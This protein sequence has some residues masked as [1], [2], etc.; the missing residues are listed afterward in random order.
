MELVLSLG[1]KN[2][3]FI[4]MNVSWD[5]GWDCLSGTLWDTSWDIWHPA[6]EALVALPNPQESSSHPRNES[7]PWFQKHCF[8]KESRI[9][10]GSWVPVSGCLGFAV[11]TQSRKEEHVSS[12][13]PQLE[14]L[15]ASPSRFPPGPTWPHL[16]RR[17]SLEVRGQGLSHCP[18]VNSFPSKFRPRGICWHLYPFAWSSSQFLPFPT[19]DAP[20]FTPL[21]AFQ[22][23]L[24]MFQG[25]RLQVFE[26]NP[27]HS[28]VFCV[29]ESGPSGV[30]NFKGDI[31]S[32]HTK[33]LRGPSLIS[34]VALVS[35]LNPSESLSPQRKEWGWWSYSCG[36]ELTQ[37]GWTLHILKKGP[38]SCLALGQHLGI[39]LSDESVFHMLGVLN[40]TISLSR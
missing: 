17:P 26:P 22:W 33:D 32:P 36:K 29:W 18:R 35:F 40:H 9:L 23:T 27:T 2:R 5:I 14:L 6:Q 25:C 30:A 39:K 15:I 11:G 16:A 4:S 24:Q 3:F 34:W 12:Q 20:P 19:G 37:Q 31:W 7:L 13:L 8:R 21:Q 38:L 28:Y 1:T 10:G